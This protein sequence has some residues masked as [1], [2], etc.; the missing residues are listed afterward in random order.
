MSTTEVVDKLWTEKEKDHGG[1]EK[2]RSTEIQIL[3]Q[4][5][6]EDLGE[7]VVVALMAVGMA[8]QFEVEEELSFLEKL[9]DSNLKMCL[10]METI[11]CM[12][13]EW[14]QRQWQGKQGDELGCPG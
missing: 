6:L 5:V 8:G 12:T 11:S 2:M 14:M 9:I 3:T 1:L 13:I 7:E 4:G 10:D